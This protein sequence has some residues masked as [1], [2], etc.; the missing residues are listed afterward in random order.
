MS[1]IYFHH[2]GAA[3]HDRETALRGSE[4]AHM[5]L[6]CQ[7]LAESAFGME[8]FGRPELVARIRSMI[9]QTRLAD[10]LLVVR[11]D[12]YEDASKF[13]RNFLLHFSLGDGGILWWKGRALNSFSI[14]LNT[15]LRLGSD[16]VKLAARLHG[17]CEVHAWVA[18]RNR[19]WLAQIIEEGLR[20]R[21]LR[22]AIAATSESDPS[23]IERYSMNW[24]RVVETLRAVDIEGPIVTSYSVTEQ[25]PNASLASVEGDAYYDLD[26][27]EAWDRAFANIDKTTELKPDGW[28][29]YVFG[30]GIS[31]LDIVSDDYEEILDEKVARAR[32]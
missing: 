18:P 7:R 27:G 22:Y 1:C 15:V 26:P 13:G 14:Q 9:P 30:D 20:T 23:K 24:E 28:N 19:T 4:R 2:R 11:G 31:V 8:G 12:K 3:R 6:M 25:F 17:Q 21:V 10:S 16:A 5:N 29:E 32:E